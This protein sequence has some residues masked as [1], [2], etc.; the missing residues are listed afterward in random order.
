MVQFLFQLGRRVTILLGLLGVIIAASLLVVHPALGQ[1]DETTYELDLAALGYSTENLT[2]PS[3]R[4]NYYFSLPANWAPQAGAYVQLNLAYTVSN[5]TGVAPALLTVSLNGEIMHTED[6]SASS[7]TS[8][9][10]EIPPESLR[11]AEDSDL[12]NLQLNLL[13]SGR[14][15]DAQLTSLTVESSSMLHFVYRERPLSLDLTLYP[16]P[17]YYQRAFETTS[18]RMILPSQPNASELEAAAMIA[19]NLGAQTYSN[20]PLEVSL[21]DTLSITDTQQH[22]VIIGSPERASLLSQL[23]LPLPL[24][25]RRLSL[26]S[27]M[28]AAVA[29]GQP[30]SY[31]LMVDNTSTAAVQSLIVEDRLSPLVQVEACQEC[32]QVTPGLLRWDVGSLEPGQTISTMVQARLDG[33][34]GIGESVEHTASLLDAAG[35]VINVDTLTATI[36]L[37]MSDTVV[38]SSAK[39]PYFFSLDGQGVPETDGIVQILVSPWSTQRAI[40]ATTGL[41]DAAV[42]RAAHALSA[43]S[44][45]PGM[46]G[47]FAIVEAT[48]PVTAS[49]A[50]QAQDITLAEMGYA[51]IVSIG[52]YDRTRLRFDVPR[53]AQFTEEAYLAL[54]LAHGAALNPISA[55][56][57]LSL[58]GLPIDSVELR[59]ENAAD[60]WTKIALPARRLLPGANRLDMHIAADWPGVCMSDDE[61]ERFWVTIYADS[62]LHLPYNRPEDQFIFD[63]AD[64]PRF[65]VTQPTL[66]DVVLLAPA[67]VTPDEAQ[68]LVQLFSFLGDAA[69]GEY[70]MPR[71]AL[72]DQA[73]PDQ[74]RGYHWILLGRPTRNPY[75]TLLNDKLPQPFISGRDEIRQQVDNIIYRLPPD[76]DLGYIQLLPVPWDETHSILVV[77]GTTDAG[78]RWSLR[79][80]TNNVLSQQ[81]RGN[82]AVMVSNNELRTANTRQQALDTQSAIPPSEI[83]TL[84][85]EP[86]ATSTPVPTSVITS[87]PRSS[88]VTSSVYLT[89]TGTSDRLGDRPR[90]SYPPLWAIGALASSILVLA[91]TLGVAIWRRG[92]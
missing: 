46:R 3:D 69:R 2:G 18:A 7:V 72:S 31:T 49:L 62:L 67:Q 83:P 48:R 76:Y 51:D 8:L 60:D 81:M 89:G 63:L 91:G 78:L 50:T 42:L 16:K 27:Q 87:T 21:G 45:L 80:L 86:T 11:L 9:R 43:Q 25:E 88:A 74:W 4:T 37:E 19:A 14:C 38:S 33:A 53:G 13:V 82:L 68:G 1:T 10:I 5:E 56:L 17:L 58:N 61:L 12:N 41:G 90:R 39:G 54:H 47:Q 28:P 84:I 64:Y 66:R 85:A 35:Q 29:S 70:F 26:H 36:A 52:R 40:I 71:V 65:L 57:E 34:L 6:F 32:N 24:R 79:A 55:T 23:D 30:F 73:T 22:L 77:T 15:E 92:T 44:S 20:L 75:I 59:R